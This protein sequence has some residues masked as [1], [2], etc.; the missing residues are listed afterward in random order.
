MTPE[1]KKKADAFMAERMAIQDQFNKDFKTLF[2]SVGVPED[3]LDE[4]IDN[5]KGHFA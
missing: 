3:I 2:L 1:Q 4:T 5:A